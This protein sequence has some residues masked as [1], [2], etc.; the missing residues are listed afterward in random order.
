MLLSFIRQ[1]AVSTACLLLAAL[2]SVSSPA[3][4]TSKPEGFDQ[5]SERIQSRWNNK[6]LDLEWDDLVPDGFRADAILDQY[7]PERIAQLTDDDPLIQEIMG[8]L[9][10]AYRS[11][12]VVG[13][14][15][16]QPVRLGGFVVPLEVTPEGITEFLLVPFFG[17]CI[18]V[19]P[20]PS[21]QILYV[22]SEIPV[23]EDTL[24]DAVWVSGRISVEGA[25]TELAQAGYTLYAEHIVPVEY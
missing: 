10:E 4:A 16:S 19:P 23:S 5:L 14:L 13:A 15:D 1:I 3:Y 9:E 2:I 18:H 6:L 25:T 21:N 24:M 8:K 17:A 22:K 7:D 20:P 12:P 11:A